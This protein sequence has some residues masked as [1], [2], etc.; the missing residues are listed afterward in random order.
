VPGPVRR[1]WASLFATL[2]VERISYL[3]QK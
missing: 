1:L 2:A 3:G